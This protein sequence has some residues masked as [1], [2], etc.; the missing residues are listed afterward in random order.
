MKPKLKLKL[1]EEEEKRQ[2]NKN[3]KNNDKNN[4]QTR[5]HTRILA[6]GRT[7]SGKKPPS[8]VTAQKIDEWL[9]T[10]GAAAEQSGKREETAVSL[11]EEVEVE[12]EGSKTD[13]KEVMPAQAAIA[14]KAMN[15]IRDRLPLALLD[16]IESEEFMD[17]CLQEFDELDSNGNGTLEPEELAPVIVKLMDPRGPPLTLEHCT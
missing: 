11:D 3:K 9:A 12:V 17:Q 15:E 13:E 14:A 16:L 7:L 5:A 10:E 2:V 1:N 6:H 4:I 8:K